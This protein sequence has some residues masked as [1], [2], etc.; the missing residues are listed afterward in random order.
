MFELLRFE[1][2]GV[3]ESATH[4]LDHRKQSMLFQMVIKFEAFEMLDWRREH[5]VVRDYFVVQRGVLV[6]GDAEYVSNVVMIFS[7]YRRSIKTNLQLN[8][9]VVMNNQNPSNSY[10]KYNAKAFVSTSF[11]WWKCFENE[12]KRTLF[13]YDRRDDLIWDRQNISL[14]GYAWALNNVTPEERK[15]ERDAYCSRAL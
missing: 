2:D 14:D 3:D 6:E 15:R 1:S 5:V 11:P 8:K 10:L 9:P 13:I 7:L 4:D 12:K